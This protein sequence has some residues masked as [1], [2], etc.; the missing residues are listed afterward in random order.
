MNTS[1]AILKAAI[2]QKSLPIL[3]VIFATVFC[4]ILLVRLILQ[5]LFN[6]AYKQY[7]ALKKAEKKSLKKPKKFIKEDEAL[8]RKKINEIP[9][10]ISE[11]KAE[12]RKNASQKNHQKNQGGSY[13]LMISEE[14]ELEKEEM[15]RTEIVDI[16]KPVGFW[17]SMILG[18]KLTYLIQSA[19]TINNRKDKGFW[20]SM[21]EAKEREAG[22]QHARGR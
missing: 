12:A 13:E 14:Q 7:Y 19:K 3:L 11:M 22:R 5:H 8:S 20:A 6:Q 9:K 21:I 10:S 18:Q 2:I 15:G 16:V 17:T 1:L 4:T